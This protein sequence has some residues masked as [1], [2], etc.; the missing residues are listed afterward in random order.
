MDLEYLVSYSAMR[1]FF[2]VS[3][4]RVYKRLEHRIRNKKPCFSDQSWYLSLLFCSFSRLKKMRSTYKCQILSH[5]WLWY[6]IS[7]TRNPSK[8]SWNTPEIQLN[9]QIFVPKGS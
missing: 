7:G 6:I 3:Y 5:R 8:S 9:V 4:K 1:L 2:N